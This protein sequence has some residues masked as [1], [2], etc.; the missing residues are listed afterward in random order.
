VPLLHLGPAHHQRRHL[1]LRLLL[2]ATL[3]GVIPLVLDL[4][5][6]A[7]QVL[8]MR[9][10]LGTACVRERAPGH[11]ALRRAAHASNAPHRPAR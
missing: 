8:L 7:P 4:V 1:I 3:L 2:P 11:W 10:R 9:G 5:A 6:L